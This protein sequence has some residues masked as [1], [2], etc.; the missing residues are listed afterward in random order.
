MKHDGSQKRSGLLPQRPR[1]AVAAPRASSATAARSVLAGNILVRQVGTVIHPGTN[2]GI[3]R[4]FTLFAL[5]DGTVKYVRS[6][7]RTIVSRPVA[8][9]A[10][11]P[12]RADGRGR[13]PHAVHRRSDDPRPGGRRRQRRDRLPPR[14]V[15]PA[16]RAVGRRRRQRRQRHARRRRAALDAARLPL[17]AHEF[18]APTGAN[19]R[20]QDKYGRG[21]EDVVLRVPVGTRC[22]TTR[23][24]EL[25]ADLREHGE[26]F[27]VAQG[28]KGG[29]GNIHFATSTDQAPRTGRAGHARRGARRSG[30]SSSCSPTS[31]CS[32]SPTSASRRSSRAVSAR[33]AQDRRLPVHDARPEPR[34]RRAVGRARIRRRRHPRAHR[35]RAAG[36]RP[37]APLPAPRRADPRA[38]PPARRDA[39]SRPRRRCATTTSSTAS[40][41]STIPSWRRGP[42]IVV[43]NKM[44]LPDVRERAK[45]IAASFARRGIALAAISAA[46]GEGTAELLES[47]WRALPPRSAST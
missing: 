43:L 6:G 47:I 35:R 5:V 23:T 28:G 44:D 2:V 12:R 4:D 41:R 19:G 13:W 34:R 20:Q 37:R 27:V 45:Q 17:P 40:S 39:P 7:P 16:G 9:R 25:L 46:T 10:L 14:E 29:R 18:D 30:S 36:R 22:S 15:R 24:G 32:A 38:R 11:A 8:E 31:A 26:R 33:P 21:G 42:Q 1:L 3:G